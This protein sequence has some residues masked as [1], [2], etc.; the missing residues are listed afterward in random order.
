MR[1]LLLVPLLTAL[2]ACSTAP[3]AQHGNAQGLQPCPVRPT[4]DHGCVPG[5][6]YS[7]DD[8]ERTGAT[9]AGGALR[10]LD[11]SVTVH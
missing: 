6:S 8:L 3:A 7:H 1:A 2:A 10:L 5:R 9:T 11:P 4:T